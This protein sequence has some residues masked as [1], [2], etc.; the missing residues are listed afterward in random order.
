MARAFIATQG[1]LLSGPA[2][3]NPVFGGSRLVGGADGD[4]VVHGCYIDIKAA[5]DPE[6]LAPSHWRWEILGYVLLDDEDRLDL[7]DLGVYLP[8][9]VMLV[10]RSLDEHMSFLAG[11][12]DRPSL[13]QARAEFQD[14]LARCYKARERSRA[15]QHRRMIVR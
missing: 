2:V 9:Q 8:R 5:A 7:H 3:L 14:M 12:D 4:L 13:A 1:R 11:D 10:T 6:K 15:M